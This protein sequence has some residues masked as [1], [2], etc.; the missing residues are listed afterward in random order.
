VLVSDPDGRLPVFTLSLQESLH[1]G[2]SHGH[3][4]L[5]SMLSPIQVFA[6]II[7][8]MSGRAAMFSPTWGRSFLSI[9]FVVIP[10]HLRP[11]WAPQAVGY[12]LVH[13]T[14]PD[15]FGSGY[16]VA[17]VYGEWYWNFGWLGLILA[18]PVLAWLVAPVDT[19]SVGPSATSPTDRWQQ[20]GSFSGLCWRAVSPTSTGRAPTRGS[21]VT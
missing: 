8:A 19:R 9:P 15:R 7:Q 4:G 12:D 6:Q 14:A 3:N 13:L 17:T 2:A 16:S 21:S 20:Y 1:A 10:Q 18:V 5:E 11:G